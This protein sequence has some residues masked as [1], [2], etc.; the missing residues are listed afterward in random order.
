MEKEN[1]IEDAQRH[2][3][4]AK[5]T[6]KENGKYDSDLRRYGDRKYVNQLGISCGQK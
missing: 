6:L 1:P 4:N 2:V 5:E 3:A